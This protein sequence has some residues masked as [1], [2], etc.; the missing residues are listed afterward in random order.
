MWDRLETDPLRAGTTVVSAQIRRKNN[1]ENKVEFLT[2]FGFPLASAA[3]ERFM[4][5]LFSTNPRRR[6]RAT[7]RC[8]LVFGGL[9]IVAMWAVVAASIV[10]ARQTAM[11]RTRVGTQPCCK[12][13]G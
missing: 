4:R 6:A 7:A 3:G 13:L 1:T 2:S 10:A 5:R 8:I 11:D 9:I 12:F